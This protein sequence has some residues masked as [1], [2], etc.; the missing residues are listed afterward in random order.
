MTGKADFDEQQWDTVLEG[1]TSAG[2]IAMS[3]E[4]GGSFRE[5]FAMAKVYGEVRGEHGESELLDEIAAQRPEIDR[6]R[7]KSREELELHA[8]GRIR[9]AVALV[10]EKASA[11]EAAAYRRFVAAVARRVAE[12]KEEKGSQGG[13]TERE[14]Q[15]L[16]EIDSA[17]SSSF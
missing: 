13:V 17:L 11:E 14:Q 6:A 15:A 3:A 5:A 4:K 2:L 9:E 1:P 8:L 10:D 12:A 16:D 7:V